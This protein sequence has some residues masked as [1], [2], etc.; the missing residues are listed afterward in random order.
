MLVIIK[1]V[2]MGYTIYSF[3]PEVFFRLDEMPQNEK[4]DVVYLKNVATFSFFSYVGLS[5]LCLHKEMRKQIL[6]GNVLELVSA[7]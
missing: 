3:L 7:Q 6:K 5:S 2:C 4:T 1:C